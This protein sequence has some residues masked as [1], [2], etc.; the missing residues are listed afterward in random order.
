[1]DDEVSAEQTA[2]VGKTQADVV[3]CFGSPI[4]ENGCVHIVVRSAAGEGVGEASKDFQTG[5]ETLVNHTQVVG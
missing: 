3:V 2:Y 5:K 4:H 1:M